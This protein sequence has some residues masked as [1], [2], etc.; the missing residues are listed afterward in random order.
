MG[1]LCTS[2]HGLGQKCLSS[3][4]LA[5][6]PPDSGWV[7]SFSIPTVTMTILLNILDCIIT[8]CTLVFINLLFL[9][10]LLPRTSPPISAPLGWNPT[11]KRQGWRLASQGPNFCPCKPPLVFPYWLT[12][13][14]CPLSS[15]ACSS[16]LGSLLTQD[17]VVRTQQLSE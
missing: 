6:A 16:V 13:L 2:N 10:D 17:R 7:S 8:S 12:P 14:L 11:W 9:S 15:R 4:F 1:A 3:T 5:T